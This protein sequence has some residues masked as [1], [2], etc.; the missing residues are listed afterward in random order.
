MT[1]LE[2]NDTVAFLIEW[3]GFAVALL[4]VLSP[5]IFIWFKKYR[6][7]KWWQL[8]FVYLISFVM[9]RFVELVT[10]AIHDDWL[11]ENFVNYGWV[12]DA[13]VGITFKQWGTFLIGWP[14]LLLYSIR[15]YKGKELSW[16][17]WLVTVGAALLFFCVLVVISAYIVVIG[18]G[19][20]GAEHF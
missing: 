7:T 19:Q 14:L 17:A 2:Q 12:A 9:F 6:P 15:L 11:R 10:S 16:G 1:Y 18:L 8:I 4:L 5:F 3:G 13:I 20:I